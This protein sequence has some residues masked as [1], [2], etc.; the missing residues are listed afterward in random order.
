MEKK[1]VI[2]FLAPDH[3]TRHKRMQIFKDISLYLV[4]GLISIIIVFIVPLLSGCLKGDIG[5]NFPD[6]LEG[7]ILYWSIQAGTVA[8]N[9]SLFILFKLQAKTNCKDHLN[10]IEANKILSKHRNEKEFIPRSPQQMNAKEYISKIIFIVV[11]SVMSFIT[12]SSL[13]IAFDF[14]TFLSCSIS[15]IVALIMGW[16]TMLKNEEYWTNEYLA[17]AK[18]FDEQKS[19]NVEQ[20]QEEEKQIDA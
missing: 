9:I 14:V 15:T 17:Y 12:I 5:M 10:Y 7:W 8:G 4:I 1:D 16:I 13:V 11:F 3:E 19:K 6:T 18:W 2:G 20:P